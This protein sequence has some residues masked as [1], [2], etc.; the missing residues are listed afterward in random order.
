M[1]E[2]IS[3]SLF[4]ASH[5]SFPFF[6]FTLHCHFVYLKYVIWSVTV[7]LMWW[8]Y[9]WDGWWERENIPMDCDYNFI[10]IQCTGTVIYHMIYGGV[11]KKICSFRAQE[12]W[13]LVSQ[14]KYFCKSYWGNKPLNSNNVKQVP[15]NLSLERICRVSN[16]VSSLMFNC[17]VL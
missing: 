3:S 12:S 13:S 14:I 16:R 2:T 4:T 1:R 9:S 7:V 17:E 8:L 5:L 11:E 15:A 6:I 10:T